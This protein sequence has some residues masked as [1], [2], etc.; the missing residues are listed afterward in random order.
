[1]IEESTTVDFFILLYYDENYF[2]HKKGLKAKELW[3]QDRVRLELIKSCGY[4]LEVIWEVE[5]KYNNNKI[6][7]ILKKYDTTIN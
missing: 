3:E 5:L 4:N 1:M 6:L 2:N 7:E